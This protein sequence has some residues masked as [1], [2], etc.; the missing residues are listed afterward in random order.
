MDMYISMDIHEN[1]VDI[2]VK[3]HFHAATP[4][5]SSVLEVKSMQ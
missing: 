1:F 2:D 4:E 3:Y 5:I